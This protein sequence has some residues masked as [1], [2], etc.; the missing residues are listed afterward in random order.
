MPYADGT[1]PST[2]TALGRRVH[3]P[4]VSLSVAAM[5]AQ[6]F[7]QAWP[8]WVHAYPTVPRPGADERKGPFHALT[9][10]G[11]RN[12]AVSIGPHPAGP[13]GVVGSRRHH[14]LDAALRAALG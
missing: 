6:Y 7:R 14:A 5:S 3:K 10:Y 2:A 12:R 4:S 13:A 8:G 11:E 9:P 1:S